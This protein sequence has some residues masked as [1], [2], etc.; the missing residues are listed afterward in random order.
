MTNNIGE[1]KDEITQIVNQVDLWAL[2]EMESPDDEYEKQVN[3]IVS[4]LVNHKFD[5]SNLKDELHK[6][7]ETKEFELD[8][9]K[10]Q[11]L[12]DKIQGLKIP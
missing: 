12:A 3:L 10:V 11:A 4:G 2:I 5:S 6:I 8:D 1:I 9:S 7:F